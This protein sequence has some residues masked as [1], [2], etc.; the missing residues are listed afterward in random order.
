[1][2]NS[3]RRNF[4]TAGLTG[5]AGVALATHAATSASPALGPH[6][7][8]VSPNSH[9]DEDSQHDYTQIDKDD[10]VEIDGLDGIEVVVKAIGHDKNGVKLHK[11]DLFQGK[12]DH[13]NS[14]QK[15]LVIAYDIQ[16]LLS[17]W[18]KRLDDDKW[19]YFELRNKKLKG[20]AGGTPPKIPPG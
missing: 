4:V 6:K 9:P 12:Q 3:T 20:P 1:M 7:Y 8:K 13:F 16:G 2:E 15:S 10:T 18:S 14:G 19:G 5:A 17:G 11:E